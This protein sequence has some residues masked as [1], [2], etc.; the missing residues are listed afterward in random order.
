MWLVAAFGK[1]EQNS[2]MPGD[3]FSVKER[4][5]LAIL[6]ECLRTLFG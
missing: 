6:D 5:E 2:Q 1:L 4:N 3:T